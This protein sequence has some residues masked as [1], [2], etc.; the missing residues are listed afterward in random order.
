[1]Q[2]VTGGP[3]TSRLKTNS[4]APTSTMNNITKPFDSTSPR[5]NYKKIEDSLQKHPGPG[6]YAMHYEDKEEMKMKEI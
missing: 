6:H 5:F 3:S 4:V 2:S 1:M